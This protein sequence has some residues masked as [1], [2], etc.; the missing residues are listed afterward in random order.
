MILSWITVFGWKGSEVM[1]MAKTL[2]H[3][4]FTGKKAPSQQ[5]VIVGQG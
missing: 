5:S 2:K 1:K 4:R 3:T